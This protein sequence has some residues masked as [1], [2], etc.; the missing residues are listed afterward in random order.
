MMNID[1]IQLIR[2]YQGVNG[3]CWFLVNKK[4]YEGYPK[5]IIRRKSKKQAIKNIYSTIFQKNK[6]YNN[7]LWLVKFATFHS[8]VFMKQSG[9]YN[10]LSFDLN[11]ALSIIPYDFVSIMELCK[12]FER[13]SYRITHFNSYRNL[14]ENFYR[15]YNWI[16]VKY[17]RFTDVVDDKKR[18]FELTKTL[19]CNNLF[20]TTIIPDEVKTYFSTFLDNNQEYDFDKRI[21]AKLELTKDKTRTISDSKLIV[22]SKCKINFDAT[23]IIS[24]YHN[25]KKYIT[26]EWFE[27]A[28]LLTSFGIKW[29]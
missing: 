22:E 23:Y 21:L 15:N 14:L 25:G 24:A 19:I 29:K 7:I 6:G 26:V 9:S 11:W 2:Q 16:P 1:C 28:V 17:I 20:K 18:F 13:R 3:L 10:I 12:V 5:C 4:Y 27:I 8:S